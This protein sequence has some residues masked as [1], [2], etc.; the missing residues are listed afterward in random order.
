M[1]YITAAELS[2]HIG[3][4]RFANL[5]GEVAADAIIDYA[6][7][8]VDGYAG[9]LYDVPLETTALV[10]AWTLSLAEYELY[11]R[12]CGS[13]VPQKI[14]DSRKTTLQQLELL[15]ERRITTGGELRLKTINLPLSPIAVKS[16]RQPVMTD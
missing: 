10:K 9:T 2:Q 7:A 5:G 1:A 11:K 4:E 15:A 14:L 16:G 6:G 12:G 3:R 13:Q 8:I